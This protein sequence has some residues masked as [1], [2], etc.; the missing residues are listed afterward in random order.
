MPRTGFG[1]KIVYL[2]L[3][4][5]ILP[6]ALTSC[7]IIGNKTPVPEAIG[8]VLTTQ[9]VIEGTISPVLIRE[10]DMKH[11]YDMAWSPDGGMFA[12]I[13]QIGENE[14]NS[15]QAFD[16]KSLNR[17]WTA[18]NTPSLD[19]TFSPNG[20]LIVESN[21][22]IGILYM[23]SVIQGSL[24]R[25]IKSDTCDGGQSLIFSP[26]GKTLLV[27]NTNGL[28]GLNP[29]YTVDF[30]L[31]DLDTGQ[32]KDLLHY[33]GSFNLFDLNS[34]GD[35]IVFG[36]QGRE[37]AAV[38]WDMRKQ[39]ELCRTEAKFGRFVPGQNILAI[40]RDQN[41]SFLDASSC[42]EVR[43]LN[44]GQLVIPYLTFSLDGRWFAVIKQSVQIMET[45]TGR[46][47]TEIPLPSNAA[48]SVYNHGLVFSP[49]S[50][51]L[52]L[53]FSTNVDN[54]YTDRVQLWKLTP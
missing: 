6:V 3:P 15:V 48:F 22:L 17:I 44:I 1:K 27:A 32:C 54:E 39:T 7:T 2:F 45:S 8:T 11:V 31:W 4:I 12:V 46:V 42:Q 49:D 19:L 24:V 50:H 47:L 13:S 29:D 51:Y 23:R 28:G 34:S 16:I 9:G 21:P 43:E 53:R 37:D 40:Y 26:D 35:L 38:I 30:S 10:W 33:I 52:L 14:S 5:I 25:Q 18:E 41:I 20:Q 36:G